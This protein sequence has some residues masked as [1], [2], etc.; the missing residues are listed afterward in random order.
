MSTSRRIDFFLMGILC[1]VGSAYGGEPVIVD[2]S[3][4]NEQWRDAVISTE[5]RPTGGRPGGGPT[6]RDR[7][8]R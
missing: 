1:L 8:P 5:V 7:V 3:F 4:I 2:T 6:Y